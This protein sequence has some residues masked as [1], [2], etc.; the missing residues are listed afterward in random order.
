MDL[1]NPVVR[2]VVVASCFCRGNEGTGKTR[3]PFCGGS[4]P[5]RGEDGGCEEGRGAG[6][7]GGVDGRT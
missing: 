6:V 7:V 2:D 4:E 1:A 3:V 5:L